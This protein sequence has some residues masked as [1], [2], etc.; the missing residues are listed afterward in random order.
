MRA[1]PWAVRSTKRQ[2]GGTS[3]APSVPGGDGPGYRTDP[4][5]RS[6]RQ[7]GR[8]AKQSGSARKRLLNAKEYN[9]VFGY[10]L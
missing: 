10:L 8:R 6:G 2:E 7:A 4:I 5:W 3:Y 1:P 9:N